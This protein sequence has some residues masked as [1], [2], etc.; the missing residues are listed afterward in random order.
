[1][2]RHRFFDRSGGVS[3]G[4][5]ASLNLSYHV[6]DDPESVTANRLHAKQSLGI[7]RLVSARQV[8]G[9]Q[10]HVVESP[11]S[12]DRE[13]DG[14][15]ALVTA[16][17]GIGLM[18]QQADC[19]AVLLHEPAAQVI[20]AIHCGWR[21]SVAGIIGKTIRVMVDRYPVDRARIKAYIGPSLGPCCAE[22][23][24]YH[25][26]L[27]ASL[28]RFQVR[29]HYFDFW[30][31]SAHQLIESGVRQN[32]IVLP[33]IC[34]SCSADYF[35]YRRSRRQGEPTTGRHGAIICL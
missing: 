34:T 2:G 9:E 3:C 28:H 14:Y 18:I 15:D 22:F 32:H 10:V 27:P 1:V 17:R 5:F 16:E 8:H 11:V 12:G 20:A 35:S 26:E 19:Q 7:D 4:S 25:S 24:N 23:V 21:G 30:Q 29:P 13:V 31:I 33:T 6:G